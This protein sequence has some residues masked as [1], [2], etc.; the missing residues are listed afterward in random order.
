MF[1]MENWRPK[2]DSEFAVE[3]EVITKKDQWILCGNYIDRLQGA[4][5]TAADTVIVLRYSPFVFMPRMVWRSFRRGLNRELL[6]GKNRES[7][8]D[9]F[10]VPTNS[11]LWFNIRQYRREGR[12]YN[13]RKLEKYGQLD[14]TVILSSPKEAEKWLVNL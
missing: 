14:K 6:W 9:F 8:F 11:L 13:L 10:F 1:H 3:V 4:S 5:V 12:D 7:L 2:P